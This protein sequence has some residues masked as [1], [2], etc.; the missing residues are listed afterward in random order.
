M[1]K[2][3]QLKNMKAEKRFYSCE[4]HAIQFDWIPYMDEIAQLINAKPN[5][6]EHI[7]TDPRLWFA[8]LFGPSVPYQYRLKGPHSWSKARET[9]LTVFDRI[10]APLKTKTLTKLKS[11]KSTNGKIFL[12]ILLICLIVFNI[13]N[14]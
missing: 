13:L 5:I 4:R 9:I 3:I 2:D 10:E 6:W 11:R 8:L 12:S 14:I 1:L 7:F